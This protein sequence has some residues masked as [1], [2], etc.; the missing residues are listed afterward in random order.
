M[1]IRQFDEYKI[2][3]S[4]LI[5]PAILALR[6]LEQEKTN[7]IDLRRKL[8]QGVARCDELRARTHELETRHAILIGENEKLRQELDLARIEARDAE[9]SRA[10][11]ANEALAKRSVVSDLERQLA[12]ENSRVNTLIDESQR[13][14]DD[15]VAAQ[16]KAS[17]HAADMG[18]A[19]DKI[20]FLEGEV[21]SLQKSL[22]QV[23]E[24]ATHAAR[25]FT[26]S[27]NALTAAKARLLQLEASQTRRRR[28]ETGCAPRSRRTAPGMVTSRAASKCRSTPCAPVRR[29]PKSC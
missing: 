13:L 15:T 21:A 11:F 26:D 1:K 18:V 17:R 14:R 10:E 27:E 19:Q 23:S 7:N 8:E 16:S 9:R 22:D 12:L 28:N 3:F 29:P 5:E 24:Q 4:K 25:R 20:E 2:T 6:T